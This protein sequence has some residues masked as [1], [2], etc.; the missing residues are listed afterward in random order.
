MKGLRPVTGLLLLLGA[1]ASAADTKLW[2]DRPAGKWETE[3][4]P[5]GNGRLGAMLFGGTSRERIQ[6]NEESLWI[7]D[8]Q[9]TGA[10]QAFGD[11]FVEFGGPTETS[12][13]GYRRELDLE[14]A[15]HTVTYR[16]GGVSYY[17][18]AFASFPA[19]VMVFRFTA[20]KPGMLTGTVALTDMHLGKIQAEGN[21]LTSAG[22]LAGYQYEGN[23]PYAIALNYEAQVL[24]L[25]KGGTVEA[26]GD[27]IAFQKANSVTLLL[28][29]GTDFVQDRHRGWRGEAPHRAIT[30]RL[31]AAAGIPYE[32]L[33]AAHL[34]D[35][36]S[37]FGRVVLDLGPAVD[38]PT[39][40]RLVNLNRTHTPDHGLESLLFQYGRYLLIAS[41]RPGGLPAN[42][43]GEW[44]QS[45]RPPWRSDY[46]TDV[47]VQMNYWLA[48][49]ANLNECFRPYAAWLNSIREV[50][51]EAT[52]AAFHTRGWTMRA[53]NGIFGGSTWQWVE[54]GS[55]WCLQNVWDHYAF[56]GDK[57]YLR[58]L[59]YPMM[60]EVCEFWLDRLKPLP[61]GTLVAPDGYSPEHGPRED[62][63][64]HDQQLIWD[65]F[66]NTV[67]AADVLGIDREFRDALAGKRDKLLGPKIG[68]WGQLQEWMVDRDDP[69][70]QHRHLSHLVALYPGRQITLQ[71][72]PAL[73]Q[74]AR[75]SLNARGDVSTGW[76]TAW[77]IN[78]WARL[79]DGDRAY[80]LI[81]NLLRLVGDTRVNYQNGGGVYANLFDAHPP[82]QIDGNFGYTAGVAEMLLQ[83][84]AGEIELLPALPKAWPTG[85][86]AGLRARG[87]FEVDIAWK[88]GRLTEAVLRSQ[89]G[90]PCTVRYG[91]HSVVLR[92]QKDAAYILDSHL[93]VRP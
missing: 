29:A 91:D 8:E 40:Q 34:R 78:L 69:N 30:E 50:R 71:K 46:H 93:A 41:S 77:K 20:D 27:T 65:L 44:N 68:R 47:N 61:D 57:D 14:R 13:T 45:I 59:A 10:Y 49:G 17:R 56:T 31:N 37:L 64:S 36:Q 72:T 73:A 86:V 12:A 74:A 2:Y 80:K 18:E 35:Y 4:L 58:A 81:G 55:A 6:F 28:D 63:V 7:G 38:L 25:N 60:K 66:N 52:A 15:V 1:S 24:V 87:G 75:V 51:H 83:S 62:G 88:E 11:V 90:N 33:L 48:G 53:E 79:H 21:R 89:H 92:T 54:S 26:T 76:S 19:R 9:D 85:R 43:Q 39:D 67:E 16:S 82:F 22:S 23:K 32:D 70:D 42:L 84:H 3:A 5:I